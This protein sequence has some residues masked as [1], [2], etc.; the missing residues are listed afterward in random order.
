[1]VADN[2]TKLC[3]HCGGPGVRPGRRC[4]SNPCRYAARQRD[5]A[6]RFWQ[7]VEKTDGCWLWRGARSTWGYGKFSFRG[8]SL[9][10]HRVAW[11]LTNGPVPAG[12]DVCHHCDVRLCVRPDHLFLGTRADNL[13]DMDQKGRRSTGERHGAAQRGKVAHGSGHHHHKLT[14]AQVRLIRTESAAGVSR[15]VLAER[16]HIAA[17]TIT[18]IVRRLA[19]KHVE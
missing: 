12:L 11:E 3:E 16:F 7:R 13:R 17:T 14:E 8:E 19:W 10:A 4:C 15:V 2:P 18:K 9:H 6:K 5:P 1:M